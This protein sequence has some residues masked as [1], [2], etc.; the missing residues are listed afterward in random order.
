MKPPLSK[1]IFSVLVIVIASTQISAQKSRLIGDYHLAVASTN[2]VPNPKDQM[3]R[4]V[5]FFEN[6]QFASDISFPNGQNFPFNQG[7]YFVQNDSVL[8]LHHIE[9]KDFLDVAWVYKYKFI[10]DTLCYKGYYT[11]PLPQNSKVLVKFYVDEKWVR[12]GKKK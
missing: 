8:V 4:R 1:L 3:D 6:N 10:G 12:I 7:V 9:N 11:M 5:T 2:G